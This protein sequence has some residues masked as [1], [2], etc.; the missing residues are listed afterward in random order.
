MNIAHNL[1]QVTIRLFAQ[2]NKNMASL[3][4]VNQQ[5]KETKESKDI[6]TFTPN[7]IQQCF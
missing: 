1:A 2:A 3:Y 4:K 7:R 5:I 6:Q